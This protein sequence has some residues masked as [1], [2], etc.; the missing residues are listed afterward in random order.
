MQLFGLIHGLS[1]NGVVQNHLQMSTPSQ[2]GC[3]AHFWRMRIALCS[4]R[5]ASAI[6]LTAA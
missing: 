5:P 2:Q 1:A 6:R 3:N 4:K